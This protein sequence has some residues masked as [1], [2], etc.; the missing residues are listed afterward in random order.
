MRLE[1]LVLAIGLAMT[2]HAVLT[3]MLMEIVILNSKH[4]LDSSMAGNRGGQV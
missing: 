2:G 4:R 3:P 1:L